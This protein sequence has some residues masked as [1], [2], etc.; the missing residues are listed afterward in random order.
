V[1]HV[2]VF[3]GSATGR[4]PV[5]AD[6]ASIVGRRIA[7]RGLGLIYGGGRVGLMGVLADA[8][9]ASGGRVV[10]V[11]PGF[12]EAREVGHSGL[13]EL[14]VVPT[15]H[16][17]KA[18]MADR[19]DAFLALPGGLGTLDELF[20]I[21]TWAQLGLHDKPIGLLNVA[22]YFDGLVTL[23]DH[24]VTEG[25]V[26]VETRARLHVDTDPDALLDRLVRP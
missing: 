14:H 15:M 7:E 12:L 11:I 9:L 10:G 19:A 18:L 6:A 8:A 24:M 4:D 5:H 25:F 1:K 17:R 21:F 2:C 22:G 26:R 16:E 3:T 20:E 13:T 23:V